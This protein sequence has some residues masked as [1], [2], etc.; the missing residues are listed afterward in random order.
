MLWRKKRKC[1]GVSGVL[2]WKQKNALR[3]QA[4][5]RTLT[6]RPYRPGIRRLCPPATG[7]RGIRGPSGGWPGRSRTVGPGPRT[8][9]A[10]SPIK[11]PCKLP[12][13][14]FKSEKKNNEENENFGVFSF[15]FIIRAQTLCW[16][17]IWYIK[18]KKKLSFFSLLLIDWYSHVTS[19]KI[20]CNV[21]FMYGILF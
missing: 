16:K 5:T 11:S 13:Y 1:Q 12:N 21:Y 8:R 17:V 20:W 19:F 2:P 6:P 10:N 14:S 4:R 3:T 18:L 15:F 9:A 7:R